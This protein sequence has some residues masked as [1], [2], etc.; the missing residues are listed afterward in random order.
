MKAD[1]PDIEMD[2][3][4]VDGWAIESG[5]SRGSGVARIYLPS[6]TPEPV[7][8][9]EE[10]MEIDRDIVGPSHLRFGSHIECHQPSSTLSE[11]QIGDE[12]ST[13]DQQPH[14]A[15]TGTDVRNQS[16]SPSPAAGRPPST[17]GTPAGSS[18]P[19]GRPPSTIGTPAGSSNPSP[20]IFATITDEKVRNTRSLFATC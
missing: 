3:N 16:R 1:C 7:V 14:S 18:N 4:L 13:K 5:L 15:G 17:I 8:Q 10:H 11:I 6:V 19:A 9:P 2:G 20:N 12:R